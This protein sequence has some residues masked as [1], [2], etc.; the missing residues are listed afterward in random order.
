MISNSLGFKYEMLWAAGT[1]TKLTQLNGGK[2]T[3]HIESH[4][5]SVE[6]EFQD[7]IRDFYCHPFICILY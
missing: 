7:I 3:I 1:E 6:G 2:D 4:S 5:D